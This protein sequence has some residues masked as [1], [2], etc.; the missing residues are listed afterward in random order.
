M[1]LKNTILK[2]TKIIATAGPSFREEED[3]RKMFKAGVNIVRLN[4]SHGTIEDH[5]KIFDNVVKIRNELDL[6]ISILL[7]TKGPEIRIN[8]IE[9]DIMP[10]K[11]NQ[12]L[13]INNK[14]DF[15][16][17]NGEFSIDYEKLFEKIKI[18]E[19]IMI[20]DG[21]LTLEVIKVEKDKKII[22]VK[23]LNSHQISTKK[24]VNI[25][26]LDL[27][28]NILAESDKKFITWG[29]KKGIDYI[30]LSFVMT[31]EDIITVRKFLSKING[32]N[33]KIISKIETLKAIDNLTNIINNS[34][35]IMFARGDLEIEIPFQKIPFFEKIIIQKCRASRIPIII[36]TQLLDSMTH[37]PKPTRAEVTDVYYA[38]QSG[39]DAVMLSGESASGEFPLETVKTMSKIAL[40]AERNY[41][42]LTS[43]EDGYAHVDSSNAESAFSI[44]QTSLTNE[45]KYIFAISEKG[46][47]LKALSV[48]R[49][50]A[51]IIGLTTSKNLRHKLNLEYGINVKLIKNKNI[52]DN[53]EKISAIAKEIGLV[54][55]TK[56]IVADK[57]NYREMLVKY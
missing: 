57:K 21:K 19:K 34:D 12:I 47:L 32:K 20:D 7:D 16:G 36:A 40:E 29:V 45:S 14:I 46:R 43:F 25:P 5:E 35:G 50:N 33:V 44:A 38:V 55:N 42:Y 2:K 49:P 3:M 51:N 52:Y 23:A 28:L 24:S 48:F 6:P 22:E 10:V 30:A 39:T 18:H 53:N 17:K 27:G 26:G 37:N 15:I 41:N 56:I 8:K 1:K 13:K 54:K 31:K 4:T 11:M 9:N